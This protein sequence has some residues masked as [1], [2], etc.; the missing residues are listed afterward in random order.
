MDNLLKVSELT[1]SGAQA[2]AYIV[3]GKVKVNGVVETR[4]RRKLRLGDLV[5]CQQRLVRIIGC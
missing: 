5:D 2:K 1:A 3:A 4:T